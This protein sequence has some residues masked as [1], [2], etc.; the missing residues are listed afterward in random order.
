MQCVASRC[1]LHGV[2]TCCMWGLQGRVDCFL[3]MLYI[4]RN[5][6]G[7]AAV[8]LGPSLH[9]LP[10]T[11]LP[12]APRSCRTPLACRHRHRRQVSVDHEDLGRQLLRADLRM[13]PA[14][15]AA[16]AADD[17]GVHVT[18]VVV[19]ELLPGVCAAE[20]FRVA[21]GV[22]T[23]VARMRSRTSTLTLVHPHSHLQPHP[24]TPP[25]TI[26]IPPGGGAEPVAF[27]CGQ[28]LGVSPDAAEGGAAAGGGTQ[29][30]HLLPAGLVAL[31]FV[32]R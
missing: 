25:P 4:C 15:P 3:H 17:W 18:E 28:W 24:Q 8:Q 14:G 10:C 31:S 19:R 6:L 11:P 2:H 13:A 21:T 26:Q 29:S 5:L 23:G 9:P 22:A 32:A 27:R 1:R 16:S 7:S 30:L 12:R 20:G